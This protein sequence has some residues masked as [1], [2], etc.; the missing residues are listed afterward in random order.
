MKAYGRVSNTA[1]TA[2]YVLENIEIPIA[3]DDLNAKFQ[4]APQRRN[5]TA[6]KFVVQS[7][8]AE[9]GFRAIAHGWL[10]SC[11]VNQCVAVLWRLASKTSTGRPD[12]R[13]R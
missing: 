2:V 1:S 9:E 3:S 11:L 7:G 5:R 4:Q 8:V 13:A 6:K 12:V 10:L